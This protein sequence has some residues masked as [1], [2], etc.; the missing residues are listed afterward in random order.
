MSNKTRQNK[1]LKRS[2]APRTDSRTARDRARAE[3]ELAARKKRD[4]RIVIGIAVAVVLLAIAGGVGFMLYRQFGGPS[5][6][7]AAGPEQSVPAPSGSDPIVYGQASAAKTV[8][9]YLDFSC[10]HCKDFEN[11]QGATLKQLAESGEFKVAYHPLS[12]MVRPGASVNAANAFACAAERGFGQ[13]YMAELF[14][15]QGL[16]WSDNQLV[17]LARQVGG[18]AGSDISGCITRRQNSGWVDAVN[19]APKPPDF[20]GTPAIYVNGTQIQWSAGMT[21]EQFGQALRAA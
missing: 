1:Q 15:N 9:V 20:T 13:A 6:S 11:E 8:D 3:A 5:G 10:P 19:G 16:Q 21:P 18:D 2:Q 17:D 7:V 14:R 4:V 12:F